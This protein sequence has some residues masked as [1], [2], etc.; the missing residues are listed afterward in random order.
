MNGDRA[1]HR[2]TQIINISH[3]DGFGIQYQDNVFCLRQQK[4]LLTE[5]IQGTCDAIDGLWV[6]SIRNEKY[7]L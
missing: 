7:K 4:V 3:E 1:A 6:V 5:F 2:A